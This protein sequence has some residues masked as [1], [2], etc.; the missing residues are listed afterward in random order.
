MLMLMFMH[1]IYPRAY[2]VTTKLRRLRHEGC[3]Q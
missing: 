3:L 2:L 1:S